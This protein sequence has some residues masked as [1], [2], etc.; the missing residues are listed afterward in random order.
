[1]DIIWIDHF[2]P[3]SFTNMLRML[4]HSFNWMDFYQKSSF[5][6]SD[7]I[8][9][10]IYPMPEGS[11]RKTIGRHC[12]QAKKLEGEF[13]KFVED[14]NSKGT[15]YIAFGSLILLDMAPENFLKSIFD[16][17]EEL[18]EYR[19][20]FSYNGPP[21]KTKTHIFLTK[22]AP[23]K[24]ILNHPTTRVY[25]THG[26]L[27]SIK[28]SIC[29]KTPPIVMPFFAEQAHNAHFILDSGVGSILNKY[30]ISKELVLNTFQE[31]LENPSYKKNME[32]L[33]AIYLDTIIPPLDEGRFY[34]EKPGFELAIYNRNMLIDMINV[35][36]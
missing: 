10:I 33:H 2:S 22:W 16:A 14:P 19:I 35:G 17:L 13:L 23:Q 11:D 32:R 27:K 15:I 29:A 34:V 21:R 7:T 20:I 24:E 3:L 31:V 9:S 18:D 6:L 5:S 30:K 8:D 25:L 36:Q 12:D 4:G 1:M 26:G 28:E